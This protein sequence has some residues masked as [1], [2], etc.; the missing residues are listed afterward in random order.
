MI[1]Y[2]KRF[3]CVKHSE[4]FVSLDVLVYFCLFVSLETDYINFDDWYHNA[5]QKGKLKIKLS[6]VFSYNCI[7]LKTQKN[8]TWRKRDL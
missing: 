8:G 7:R 4:A 1:H 2:L 3:S 5:L 6:I